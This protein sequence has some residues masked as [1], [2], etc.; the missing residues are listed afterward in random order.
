MATRLSKAP[1]RSYEPLARRLCKGVYDLAGGEHSQWVSVSKISEHIR[2]KD[3]EML[4]GAISFA[5]QNGWLMVGG[6]P[7]HS[8]LLTQPGQ[9][10]ALNKK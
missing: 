7:V 8:V 5:A 2:V 1:S 10:A 4:N 9:A 3:A 6:Q